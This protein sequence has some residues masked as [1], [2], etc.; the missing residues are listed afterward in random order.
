MSTLA[1]A[2]GVV[3]VVEVADLDTLGTVEVSDREVKMAE[4]LVESYT[5]TFD[6]ITVEEWQ[7]HPSWWLATPGCPLTPLTRCR[8]RC[9][10]RPSG[11][12]QPQGV[13]ARRPDRRAAAVCR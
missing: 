1:Y 7:R 3:P 8:R 10:P 5:D 12:V 2:D 11:P 4:M 9:R 13:G 6:T